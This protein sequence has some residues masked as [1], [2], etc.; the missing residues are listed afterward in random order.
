[1]ADSKPR[2][3]RGFARHGRIEAQSK[4]SAFW[5]LFFKGVAMVVGA[6]VAVAG[7]SF[8]DLFGTIQGNG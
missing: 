8:A 1:M 2:K 6:A 4:A 7:F 3:N 5:G